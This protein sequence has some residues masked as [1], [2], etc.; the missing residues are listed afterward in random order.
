MKKTTFS[1]IQPSGIIHIGNYLGAIKNWVDMLDAYDC[2]FSVVD[3]HAITVKY[4]PPDLRE[5]I[6]EAVKTL[7]AAGIDP[8]RCT[9]FIQSHV[10]EHMELTWIFNS[11]AL[12]G[13]LE[14]MT[15]YKEKKLQN[16]ENLNAG[17]LTYPVLQASDI[18][19]YKAGV[20]PVG[21]DQEQHLELT[22]EIARRFNK[23]FGVTFPEPQT[24]L[25]K[26]P[27]IKGLDGSA[28]MSKSANNFIA[29][30]EE[31]QDIWDKLKVAVT[32]PA[33]KRRSDPGNPYI[34]NIF[35][36]HNCFSSKEEISYV[37]KGCKTAGIGCIDCKRILF[38][39]IDKVIAPIR[40]KKKELDK[41]SGYIRE[42]VAGG[43]ERCRQRAQATMRE[44]KE[45]IGVL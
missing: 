7:I 29:L 37:E 12:I 21:E 11:V 36:L 24:L 13:E 4:E 31:R 9:L 30:V 32:D 28:K 14:R 33:R 43:G 20:V 42:V 41:K 40:E 18:L 2:I 15:Q 17:L 34:C 39:N 27:R 35:A 22:R 10:P 25:S 23:R 8:E 38:E 6:S 19:L 44:V 16:P 3:Y 5:R 1:G 45:K 26:V